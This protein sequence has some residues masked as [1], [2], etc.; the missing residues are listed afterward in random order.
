MAAGQAFACRGR[1]WHGAQRWNRR[2]LV[3]DAGKALQAP[4]PGTAVTRALMQAAS[5]RFA[6]EEYAAIIKIVEQMAGTD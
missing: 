3:L 5:V 2:G 1:S 6:G 4:L